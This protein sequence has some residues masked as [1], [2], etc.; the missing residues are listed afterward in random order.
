MALRLLFFVDDLLG[1]LEDLIVDGHH[2][3][4]WKVEGVES[5][6]D[7]VA[8]LLAHLALLSPSWT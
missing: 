5:S 7:L 3:G 6:V 2:D 1:R 8:E 4:Q